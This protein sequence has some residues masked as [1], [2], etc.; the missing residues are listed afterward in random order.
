MPPT[1]EIPV[2]ARVTGFTHGK[3]GFGVEQETASTPPVVAL[4][5]L[6]STDASVGLEHFAAW[7]GEEKLL[8]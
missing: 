6:G 1:R 7:V 2:Q 5:G 8:T 4:C 3:K